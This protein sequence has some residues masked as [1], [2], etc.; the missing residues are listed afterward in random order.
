MVQER[1]TPL[2]DGDDPED[3][4][5]STHLVYNIDGLNIQNTNELIERL[6]P[7]FYYLIS[8]YLRKNGWSNLLT[9]VDVYFPRPPFLVYECDHLRIMH[10]DVYNYPSGRY[11]GGESSTSTVLETIEKHKNH[12]IGKGYNITFTKSVFLSNWL[13]R[14]EVFRNGYLRYEMPLRDRL[15]EETEEEEEE[16]D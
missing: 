16:E 13:K 11:Y 9:A 2:L 7:F 10:F 3:F 1:N 15:N 4:D 12:Y 14:S 5:T 8:T 6:T